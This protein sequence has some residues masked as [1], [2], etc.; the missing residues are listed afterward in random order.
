MSEISGI[1]TPYDNQAPEGL[2]DPVGLEVARL[3][4]RGIGVLEFRSSDLPSIEDSLT[5]L[6]FEH[7]DGF[8]GISTV[9]G[10]SRGR[11]GDLHRHG[12]GPIIVHETLEGRGLANF[13][14]PE[15]DFDGYVRDYTF[16]PKYDPLIAQ[17]HGVELSPGSVIVFPASTWHQ[18][19]A[20]AGERRKSIF[21]TWTQV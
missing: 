17:A 19:G 5:K 21:D 12:D 8:T 3:V 7:L 11:S 15:Y 6:G 18:F 14:W 4:M 10:G 13:Y 9:G 2:T 20:N 1:E 16:D